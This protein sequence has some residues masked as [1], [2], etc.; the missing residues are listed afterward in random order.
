VEAGEGRDDAAAAE[1]KREAEVARLHGATV[2]WA[3]EQD[4][5][6]AEEWTANVT[7]VVGLPE[8]GIKKTEEVVVEEEG[9]AAAAPAETEAAAEA[10]PKTES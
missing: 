8:K 1:K 3:N 10:P 4:K 5:Y 6:Y 7:H 9:E 2:Y